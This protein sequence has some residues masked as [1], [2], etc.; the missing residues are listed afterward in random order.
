[1]CSRFPSTRLSDAWGGYFVCESRGLIWFYCCCCGWAMTRERK[2]RDYLI[3]WQYSFL[4]RCAGLVSGVNLCERSWGENERTV[5]QR[6][7]PRPTSLLTYRLQKKKKKKK[8]RKKH[9]L[10]TLYIATVPHSP[11]LPPQKQRKTPKKNTNTGRRWVPPFQ[12]TLS[13]PS[14]RIG[15]HCKDLEPGLHVETWSEEHAHTDTP[16]GK[17][18]VW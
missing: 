11:R 7:I 12:G 2:K 15:M 6:T 10:G 13:Q 16:R 4:P 17:K 5:T 18:K 8:K 14:P 3:E 9:T 1:M